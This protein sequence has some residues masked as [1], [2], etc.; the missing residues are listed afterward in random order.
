MVRSDAEW[1]AW[2]SEHK[3]AF[4]VAPLLETRR[5]KNAQVGFTL[6]LYA[7]FPMEKPAGPERQEAVR[8]LRDEL[9]AVLEAVAPKEQRQA[10]AQL[11]PPKAAVLRPE[12]ES[13]PEV[14]LMW[15]LF[16]PKE[17]DP[18]TAGDRERLSGLAKRLI[19]MG[20]RQG[21]W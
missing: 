6:S 16:H 12:N 15:R 10:R 4:E 20:L 9:I 13:K 3:A 17:E 8:Q 2:A 1:A 19:A 21:H 18:L 11:E 14:E 7:A 5:G